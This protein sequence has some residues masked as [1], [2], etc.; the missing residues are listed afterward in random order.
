MSSQATNNPNQQQQCEGAAKAAIRGTALAVF[1]R[2]LS[3][4][5]SQMMLR[6]VDAR[7][8]GQAAI[9]LD[10]LLSTCLFMGREGFRLSLM[11]KNVTYSLHNKYSFGTKREEEQALEEAA[12][13][14]V[15]WLSA[16][17]GVLSAILGLL[18]H[19]YISKYDSEDYKFAG[20]LFCLGA[21][22][23]SI[24]EPVLILSLRLM[25]VE[26]RA[27]AEGAAIFSKAVAIIVF[28]EILSDEMSVSAFGMAQLVYSIVLT[29]ILYFNMRPY[30]RLPTRFDA[31]NRTSFDHRHYIAV[32]RYPLHTSSLALTGT[33]TLQGVFKH[34]LTKGDFIVLS[35]MSGRY[36]QGIYAM[37]NSY[38]GLAS[39]IL[40]QPLEE[41]G[42]HLFSR[43][44]SSKG[45]DAKECHDLKN[46]YTFLLKL[47]LYIGLI[48]SCIA[49]NYTGVLLKLLAGTK[50]SS[51][52]ASNALA[53][54]CFYTSTL[55]LNGMSEA[56][57]Y[58]VVKSAS[59]IKKL[60]VAHAI[61]GCAFSVFASF[62]VSIYGTVGLIA[63]NSFQ[64]LLRS[65][66][67][68]HFA[69]NY[70]NS[71]RNSSGIQERTKKLSIS[72]LFYQ[73]CPSPFS[74][75]SFL[76]SFLITYI[77]K[78]QYIEA[79]RD[80]ITIDRFWVNESVRHVAIGVLCGSVSAT[81]SYKTEYVL[82]QSVLS[83]IKLKYE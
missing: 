48:F 16:P 2:M 69:T 7:T 40:L 78:V 14:N 68:I 76:G 10:L 21:M 12:L 82:R 33:F 66:Y 63:A 32:F 44:A 11:G 60:S 37:A 18:I 64:M 17:I 58:G 79:T 75:I 6:R 62:S 3:F 74:L 38:G 46:A 52:E 8:L 34:L 41:N 71:D 42:R 27:A 9:Q 55:A 1:L 72:S 22:I 45:R 57:V 31:K 15:M 65:F 59:E 53:S 24:S 23:E 36:D 20:C 28:L 4:I 81:I 56:F 51:K 50:W 77:S 5:L 73:C 61:I 47:V 67:S 26:I 30:I 83:L 25:K 80:S 54:F 35:A 13:N 49:S 39:R 43:L 19:L 70:F 29:G